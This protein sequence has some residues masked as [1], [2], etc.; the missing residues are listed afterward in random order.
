MPNLLKTVSLLPEAHL[1]YVPTAE[2]RVPYFENVDL[3]CCKEATENINLDLWGVIV[4]LVA[5]F[6]FISN[7]IVSLPVD[8]HGLI[9]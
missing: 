9:T 2:R 8:G 3:S 5:L 1:S 7:T 6:I 4:L